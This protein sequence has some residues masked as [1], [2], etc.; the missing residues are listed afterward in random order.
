[1]QPELY[2]KMCD[3]QTDIIRARRL[4]IFPITFFLSIIHI[5]TTPLQAVPINIQDDT[6]N[7]IVIGIVHHFLY[8]TTQ[9]TTCGP[10]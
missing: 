8:S 5:V 1:M 7:T 2:E 3:F 10:D 9:K 6:F 4:Q